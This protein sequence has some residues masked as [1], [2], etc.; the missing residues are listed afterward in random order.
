M[1]PEIARIDGTVAMITGSRQLGSL[2]RCDLF[3]CLIPAF[4]CSEACLS[5]NCLSHEG[6]CLQLCCG[7]DSSEHGSAK[8]RP[9]TSSAMLRSVRQR[10]VPGIRFLTWSVHY[11]PRERQAAQFFGRSRVG[12]DALR[13]SALCQVPDPSFASAGSGRSLCLACS[14]PRVGK[15]RDRF[16]CERNEEPTKIDGQRPGSREASARLLRRAQERGLR[17]CSM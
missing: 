1:V 17:P 10:G 3:Q 14:K 9:A 15:E 7:H 6:E 11:A 2:P 8:S 4:S 12:H 16:R 5:V 13:P